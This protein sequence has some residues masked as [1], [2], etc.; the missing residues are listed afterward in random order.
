MASSTQHSEGGRRTGSRGGKIREICYSP[1]MPVPSPNTAGTWSLT[2]DG[3][4]I[5]NPGPSAG[6]AVLVRPDGE[7]LRA[8]RFLEKATNNQAEYAGLM[9]GLR[10][11]REAGA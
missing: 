11:A 5:G 4:S 3:G 1:G 8:S 6:A 2:F 9:C 10:L 7:T